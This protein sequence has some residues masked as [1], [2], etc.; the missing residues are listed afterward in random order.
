MAGG[1]ARA[2]DDGGPAAPACPS[3][4]LSRYHSSMS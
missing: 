2:E 3:H 4:V 1:G